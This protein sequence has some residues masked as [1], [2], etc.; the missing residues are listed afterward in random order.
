MSNELRYFSS[1]L[2]RLR[3]GLWIPIEYE[4]RFGPFTKIHWSKYRK[5]SNVCQSLFSSYHFSAGD[6]PLAFAKIS[7]ELQNMLV[8]KTVSFYHFSVVCIAY[9]YYLTVKSAKDVCIK[10]YMLSKPIQELSVLMDSR[11]TAIIHSVKGLAH[12]YLL[13]LRWAWI[14]EKWSSDFCSHSSWA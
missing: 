12:T 4:H 14:T 8:C 6:F 11:W 9:T 3:E 2:G 5:C 1:P 13:S 7:W 10:S